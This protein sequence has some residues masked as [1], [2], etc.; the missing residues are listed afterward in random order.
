M[1]ASK[2]LFQQ[3]GVQLGHYLEG[4]R[5]FQDIEAFIASA[6]CDDSDDYKLLRRLYHVLT[7]L[8]LDKG[9]DGSFAATHY[10]NLSLISMSLLS[11]SKSKI[12]QSIDA[13]W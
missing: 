10:E 1:H 8:E 6:I 9:D 2:N 4:R 11:G 12:E 5:T 13:F 7:H 3:L